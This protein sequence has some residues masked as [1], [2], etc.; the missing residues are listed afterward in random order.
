MRQ[1]GLAW[2]EVGEDTPVDD[3]DFRRDLYR[4][5]AQFCDRF[6]VHYPR[7]LIDDLVERSGAKGEG[8]LLDLAC[9]TGLISFAL[10]GHFRF[11]GR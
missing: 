5:T 2:P 1:T 10:R 4:G 7:F 3:P 8:R 11:V 6:R 9:G